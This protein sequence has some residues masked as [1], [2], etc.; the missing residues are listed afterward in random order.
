MAMKRFQHKKC[1]SGYSFSDRH[2]LPF[3]LACSD[4]NIPL[5]GPHRTQPGGNFHIKKTKALS[6]PFRDKNTVL[7]PLGMFSLKMSTEGAFT[8]PFMVLGWKISHEKM[9]CFRIGTSWGGE[10][11]FKPR[12]QNRF[13]EPLMGSFWNFQWSPPTLLYGSPPGTLHSFPL[14]RCFMKNVSYH[15]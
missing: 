7:V 15:Y 10:K 11:H 9:C 3:S 4:G 6:V 12:S 14:C 2:F 5:Q 8:L 1:S 13:L